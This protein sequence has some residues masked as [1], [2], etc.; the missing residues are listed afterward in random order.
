[1]LADYPFFC[2]MTANGRIG[3]AIPAFSAIDVP[4]WNG[5]KYSL[6]H[7]RTKTGKIFLFT[8]RPTVFASLRSRSVSAMNRRLNRMTPG[9]IM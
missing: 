9:L 2:G 4:I 8:A 7:I 6:F 3:I 1:M 5:K